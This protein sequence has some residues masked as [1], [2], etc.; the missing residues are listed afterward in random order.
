MRKHFFSSLF[1]LLNIV[2]SAQTRLQVINDSVRITNAEL[3]I[4]NSTKDVQGYLYN[5]GNGLTQFKAV[6]NSPAYQITMSKT[7]LDTA[8]LNSSLKAGMSYRITGVSP[9]L[10]GGTDIIV[11]A[12]TNNRISINGSG[13]F[14]NPNYPVYA[15]YDT[16]SIYT[17]GDTA[18]W[19]GYVWVNTS[20]S[21]G[22]SSDAFTLSS[23][24][25]TK[26][27]Y[28][29]IRYVRAWDDIKYNYSKDYIFYRRDNL[30]NEVSCDST[31]QELKW[32][33]PFYAAHPIKAFKWG[34]PKIYNNTIKESYAEFINIDTASRVNGNAITTRSYFR[35]NKLINCYLA[36]N[37]FERY[38][39]V[40]NN[41]FKNADISY[42]SLNEGSMSGNTV[43]G[44]HVYDFVQGAAI[45]YNDIDK[46]Q[47]NSNTIMPN[48]AYSTWI[49]NNA[50][51]GNI[52]NCYMTAGQ[53]SS[54]FF[55]SGG[56]SKD[57]LSGGGDITN[58]FISGNGATISDCNL[59]TNVNIIGNH[60]LLTGK[61]SKSNYGVL[62]SSIQS[63][64]LVPTGT[65]SSKTYIGTSTLY[66]PFADYA[67]NKMLTVDASGNA[68]WAYPSSILGGI[69]TTSSLTYQ[70]TSATGTTG[71]DH[72]FKVGN[73]GATEAMR[74][75]NNGNVG[76]GTSPSAKLHISG[77]SEQLRIG[78]DAS[79]YLSVSVGST[80]N[81]TISPT[82][83]SAGVTINGSTVTIQQG[84]SNRMTFNGSTSTTG[85]V[86]ITAGSGTTVSGIGFNM[87]SGTYS[88]TSG[89]QYAAAL[90]PT[91]SQS[92]TAGYTALLI[93]PKESSVGTGLKN[94][95]DVGTNTGETP[96]THTS[97]F[98]IDNTGK[99][100]INS[101][102]TAS[103]T[104]GAQTINKPS[105]SVNFAVSEQTLVVTNSTVTASSMIFLVI[106]ANSTTA[107]T[108]AYVSAKSAG[109][110]TIRLNAAATDETKV[111]FLVLN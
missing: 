29:T 97:L 102:N 57:T 5:A 66:L 13:L 1:L 93:S 47:I 42:N 101:T 25:W 73:N 26:L 104:T 111:N 54:N 41:M 22:T 48:Q 68:T 2:V 94:L 21:L 67:A 72:I 105:G 90:L 33:Y 27:T 86:N 52:T 9:T 95:L 77:T 37:I 65:T 79:N 43:I 63:Y 107:A 59:S 15:F 84:A 81:A 78:Y 82:G 70:T 83:T 14:Y 51:Q 12:V 10:Y 99:I 35:N 31:S 80:G 4:R 23:T 38:V 71:A 62:N 45:F 106:E 39:K 85:M 75:L 20:G 50:G 91:I 108:S 56:I 109:S 76:I 98:R 53:I 36:G 89:A 69:S 40:E 7:A 110:F 100:T 92:S 8:I 64:T 87:G 46:G 6:D 60:V 61:I 19:G 49:A 17:P 3:I 32:Y 16:D 88:S 24:D 55:A 11:S 58:N 28:D 18:T 103:G 34:S 96:A 44:N 30:N 74:I